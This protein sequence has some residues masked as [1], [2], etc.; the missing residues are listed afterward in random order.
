MKIYLYTLSIIILLLPG[1]QGNVQNDPF[2]H[3]AWIGEPE[4]ISIADSLM[5]GDHLAP[6]F[7]KEFYVDKEVHSATLY[8]TAAGYYRAFMNGEDI[9]AN[10]LDPAWTDYSKRIFY[11]EYD[12]T[13][14]VRKGK[15]C[16]GTTLGNGFYNPLPLKM[17]GRR[18]MRDHLPVGQPVF[19]ARLELEFTNGTTEEIISDRTWKY[20][21]GPILKNNVYLGEVYDGGKEIPGWN[22]AGFDDADWHSSVENEGPGGPLQQAF[23]PP[24]QATGVIKP[25]EISSPAEGIY[26]TDMGRNFT[27]LYRINLKGQRGDTVTFRF[28]ERL[29][30]NGELN[31]MT[32]VC[33]QIKREGLGGPGAPAIAWQTDSY[34]FGDGTDIWYSP[35]FTF[36]TYRY[37][38]IS[39]LEQ[40]PDPS[41][42]EGINIH[43]NVDTSNNFSCSSELINAIQ[44]ASRRT[45]LANLIGVQTDCPAREKFGYGGDLNSIAESY[46]N[47]FDMQAFYRKTVYD[48]IDAINDTMFIDTAPFV[49]IRYCGLSWESAFLITQ[50]YLYLYYKDIE[51]VGELYEFDLKWMEKAAR[52]HPEAIVDKGLS[53]HESLEP[54]PVELTGTSH[55]LQCARIMKRFAMLMDDKENEEHFGQLANELSKNLLDMFWRKP[56]PGPINRQTLFSTLLYHNIIP[57][58][59]QD[60]AIDSLIKAL[61]AGPSGHFTTGIFGTKY[62]LEALSATENVNTVYNIVN[63]RIYPGWGY[64]IDR[65]AT[66]IWETW[67]ESDNIYSNCHPMFGSVSEWLYRW[68]AGIRPHPDYPGFE[69]FTIAPSLPAGLGHVK[70]SYHS[71]FGEIVSNWIN[72]GNGKQ[73]FEITIPEGSSAMVRLPVRE[74]QRIKLTEKNGQDS[75]TPERDGTNHSSFE[76]GPGKY[77]ISVFE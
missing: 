3:A 39:G 65:G 48:W 15:N 32:T 9:G 22:T 64:M 53:D 41:E 74:Y 49:G 40:K 72:D 25:V 38:E 42:I 33:G 12:I 20:A 73:V 77:T 7:R 23:F 57:E 10:Y 71:P 52:L 61:E 30:E 55:Y 13:A 4:A 36:H 35:T 70:C 54:V 63:S 51:L 50:Y 11:A 2:Q 8:I 56:V 27:G 24:I 18:N 16:I 28:G 1:C 45:F 67:K 75:Y 44:Q 43:T 21:Y 68:L 47:N 5:Y 37:M 17:F 59:E 26:I 31:P 34:I 69:R 29:Y 6:L 58:D 60:A 62:I 76:L 14:Q 66:T 19:I 46:I